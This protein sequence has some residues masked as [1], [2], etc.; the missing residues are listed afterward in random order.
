MKERAVILLDSLT[1]QLSET[2]LLTLSVGRADMNIRCSDMIWAITHP[3]L[4]V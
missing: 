2:R 4:A 1:V 3:G